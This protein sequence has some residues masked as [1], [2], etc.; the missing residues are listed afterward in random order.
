SIRLTLR[1]R[2]LDHSLCDCL[3]LALVPLS[4]NLFDSVPGPQQFPPPTISL[5]GSVL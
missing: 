1:S 3:R 4:H 5:F 2:W